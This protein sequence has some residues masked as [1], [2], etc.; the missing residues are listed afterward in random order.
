MRTC[1]ILIIGL[2]LAVAS[3]AR[4]DVLITEVSDSS[5]LR[6]FSE[7][8]YVYYPT[9]PRTVD[10]PQKL[11][12]D[13]AKVS[14][15]PLE[16]AYQG[17][18][19]QKCLHD[20][21][22]EWIINLNKGWLF[23]VESS[24]ESAG[25]GYKVTHVHTEPILSHLDDL[26]QRSMFFGYLIANAKTKSTF[27]TIP[28]CEEHCEEFHRAYVQKKF[29][30][31]FLGFRNLIS[32]REFQVVAAKESDLI[33]ALVELSTNGTANIKSA[34]NTICASVWSLKRLGDDRTALQCSLEEIMLDQVA[35]MVDV[36]NVPRACAPKFDIYDGTT[37]GKT[38]ATGALL[39]EGNKVTVDLSDPKCVSKGG[40]VTEK[41]SV[42]GQ[43]GNQSIEIK[44]LS[45]FEKKITPVL[46]YDEIVNL[47]YLR[48]IRIY[49]NATL[50]SIALEIEKLVPYE[51]Q[52]VDI[53]IDSYKCS[54]DNSARMTC[55]P[56]AGAVVENPVRDAIVA[57][58]FKIRR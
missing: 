50:Q 2:G 28:L 34:D 26:V 39:Y 29:P 53:T 8:C 41:T 14:K 30:R 37:T 3:Y 6:V 54:V 56:P 35:Q 4:A 20:I 27:D 13:Y 33:R 15:S 5:V 58:P 45:H 57:V 32:N 49:K 19:S 48:E 17:I 42:Y 1:R 43:D 12:V 11:E 16:S 51:F 21:R 44:T 10:D 9:T 46:P 38:W 36:H 24:S 7:N 47:F 22:T 25:L 55:V 31:T 40:G 18:A 23:R 52:L